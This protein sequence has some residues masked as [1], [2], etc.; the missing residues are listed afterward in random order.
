M[1]SDASL[2]TRWRR[3]KS[4][5]RR[6]FL[7]VYRLEGD[8][9]GEPLSILVADDGSTLGYIRALAFPAGCSQSRKGLVSVFRAMELG[10]SN[11]D[12][13]VVG[14]SQ[15][16]I[17]RYK[18]A[19]FSFAPKAVRV[20]L[21][22]YD[23]PDV[24]VE[25]LPRPA[26]KD[27]RRSIRRMQEQS[28]SYEV[29]N[30][31][32]WFDMF[33]HEMYKPYAENKFGDLARIESYGMLK[34]DFM[35]GMGVSISRNGDPVAGGISWVEDTTMV[36]YWRGILHGDQVVAHEGASLALY[37]Y[38]IHLAFAMG[39]KVAD[40]GYSAPFV[41]DGVLSYKL[42]WGMKVETSNNSRRVYAI[43]APARTE[44]ALRF[45]RANPFYSLTDKGVGL[46]DDF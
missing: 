27:L 44:Q 5:I 14:G 8:F 15:L 35:R 43:A 1:S 28:F 7:G 46:C 39:C 34:R 29:T 22:I 23:E 45:L 36:N 19:G 38:R 6:P 24:M 21:S 17:D 33:Y 12:L 32:Q 3:L 25:R 4:L 11:A 9:A 10:R 2:L 31:E 30:D 13:V 16:L 26:R 20:E 42:K 37:Y 41:S 18:R 40:F